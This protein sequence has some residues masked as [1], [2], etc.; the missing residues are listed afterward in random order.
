MAEARHLAIVKEVE[1]KYRRQA[2]QR[3]KMHLEHANK[4]ETKYPEAL[5]CNAFSIDLP[6]AG[7]PCPSETRASRGLL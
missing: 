6:I 3:A 2:E 4:I 1:V 5:R 7:S